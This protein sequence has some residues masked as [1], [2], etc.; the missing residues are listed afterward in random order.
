MDHK[1][2]AGKSAK[3]STLTADEAVDSLSI[4]RVLSVSCGGVKMTYDQ[5]QEEG[6]CSW[7]NQARL[8]FGVLPRPL[9]ILVI[10]LLSFI[11]RLFHV[12]LD[13]GCHP[14]DCVFV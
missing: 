11:I 7:Q 14:I 5:Q 4:G 3:E 8:S 13:L 10:D 1:G 6:H 2:S 12:S 9:T